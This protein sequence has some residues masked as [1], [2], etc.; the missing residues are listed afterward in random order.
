MLQ[1]ARTR[2]VKT[3]RCCPG[4][5]SSHI[6]KNGFKLNYLLWRD[7][8][9]VQLAAAAESDEQEDEDRIDDM[10]ADIGRE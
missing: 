5:M 4:M 9:E 8:R 1:S 3:T 10:I 7:H 6:A 2:S